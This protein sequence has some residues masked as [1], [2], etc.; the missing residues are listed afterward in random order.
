MRQ[1][2]PHPWTTLILIL[3]WL[4]LSNSLS[5]ANLLAALVLGIALPIYTSHFWPLRQR[6]GSPLHA[7]VLSAIVAWDILMANIQVAYIVLF[8]ANE[9]VRSGLISIPVELATHEAMTALAAIITLTPGTV[10][11]D[12]S[13]DGR[14]LL[15]HCLDVEDGDALVKYIKDRY[16]K[17]LKK[18]FP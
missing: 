1:W 7:I 12:F 15:V 13:N 18:V 10:S 6:I 16:E 14:F 11:S 9:K 5:N 3:V 2:L 8:R 4:A 17:R